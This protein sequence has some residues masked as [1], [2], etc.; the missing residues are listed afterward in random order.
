MDTATNYIDIERCSA[1]CI[2]YD[3]IINA[4]SY[5]PSVAVFHLAAV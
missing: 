1:R 4:N 2:Y 5:N 3:T